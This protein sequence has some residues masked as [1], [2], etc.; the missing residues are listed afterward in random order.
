MANGTSLFS[1][2]EWTEIIESLSLSIREGQIMKGLFAD[3]PD[4]KIAM[5]LKMAVPTVRTHIGRLFRK[6]DADDRQ[7][8]ML[9]VFKR[10]RQNC[11]KLGCPRQR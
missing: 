10:F 4:K 8:L 1:D 7:D 11:K 3:K 9:Q 6:L 5:D 2:T